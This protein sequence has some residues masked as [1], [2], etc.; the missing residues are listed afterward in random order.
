MARLYADEQ[1]PRPVVEYL[2][3]LG[4][5][6]LTVQAAGNS[7]KSDPEVLAFAIADDRA[8]LTQNRRDFVKLHRSQPAHPGMIICS[9]DQNFARLAERIHAAI[10]IEE[11]LSGKLIRVM[12]PSL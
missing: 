4:H 2:R 1:F 11:T 7:G 10:A 12:R 3:S 8:V 5:D 6:V 9:D